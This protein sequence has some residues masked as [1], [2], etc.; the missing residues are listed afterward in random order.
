MKASAGESQIR[1]G[2]LRNGVLNVVSPIVSGVTALLLVPILLNVLGAEVY[3]VWL[4][5]MA[6]V[7]LLGAADF[8]LRWS[9]VRDVAAAGSTGGEETRRFLRGAAGMILGSAALGGVTIALL[10]GPLTGGW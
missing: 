9:V 6:L 5:V 3:G 8:G 7:T 4:A 2:V 10:G 1:A